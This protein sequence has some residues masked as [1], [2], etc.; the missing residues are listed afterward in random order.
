MNKKILKI[1]GIILGAIIILLIIIFI[2]TKIKISR[3]DLV[4]WD[5]QWYTKE[6]LKKKF[7]PQYIEV[8]EKN[9]PEEVYA[10]FRTAL[11]N[12]DYETA[13]S[14]IT[15]KNREGYR[16]AF[17]DKEKLDRWVKRLPEEIIKE[18]ES[19]NFAS[20]HYINFSDSSDKM[21]HPINL[22]KNY[23]GYWEIDSI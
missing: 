3:G 8:P 11:L 1:G 4:K 20:Y 7:P 10:K 5:G 22:E 2:D 19:G 15:E 16:D 9:T 13:L 23:N 18:S 6:Q 21:A 14:L 17:K 12:K